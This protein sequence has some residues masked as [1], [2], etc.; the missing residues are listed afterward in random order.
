M[1]H[2]ISLPT[3]RYVYVL[4]RSVIQMA[5]DKATW[6]DLIPCV[7]WGVSVTPN[8]MLGCNLLLE[9]GAMVVDVPLSELRW[10]DTGREADGRPSGII[11][12]DCYG[13][14]AEIIQN[15]YLANTR[16]QVLDEKHKKTGQIG[17]LWFAIDHIKDGFS[18]TPA[19]HK[20]LW[21]VAMWSKGDFSWVP[22]DQLLLED[23][24][25]T[26]VPVEVPR[27]LRQDEYR[28]VE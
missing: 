19:Q 16:V 21:V 5:Y 28:S 23:K 2:N 27:I 22:Q 12:W 15:D 11:T 1:S 10:A 20:H 25:F 4:K 18:M 6:D 24:S 9:N 17:T 13:W 7:W 26:D 3:H 14:D 8:R